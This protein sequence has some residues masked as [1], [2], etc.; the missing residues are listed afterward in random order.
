MD[1][2]KAAEDF[3]DLFHKV[4]LRFHSRDGS[5]KRGL[6]ME[7]YGVL[8]HLA[9]TGPLTVLEAA[10]HLGRSQAATSEIVSRLETRGLLVRYPDERDRRRHL[11]WMSQAGLREWRR[12]NRVLSSPMLAESFSRLSS[13]ERANLLTSIKRLLKSSGSKGD[14][15]E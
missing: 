15:H 5:A 14:K 12:A 4:F 9:A 2:E 8:E 11:V 6:T 7:S 1:A 10:R 3:I 13:E